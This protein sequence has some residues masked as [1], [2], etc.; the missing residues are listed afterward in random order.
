MSENPFMVVCDSDRQYCIRLSEYIR[1]NLSL[2]FGIEAYTDCEALKEFSREN[3]VSLL[4]ISGSMA[5][6]LRDDLGHISRN[7]LILTDGS[8]TTFDQKSVRSISKYVPARDIVDAILDVCEEKASDFKGFS[9]KGAENKTRVIGFYTPLSRSG[10]TTFA[11]HMG[12]KLSEKGRSLLLSF[13]SFSAI[14]EVFEGS[15]NGDITDLLYL[16]ECDEEE[17][18]IHLEKIRQK[19]NGLDMIPPPKMAMQIRELSAE[20]LNKLLRL[21]S[22][23]GGYE[24]ILLDLKDYPE[25]FFDILSMCDCI[26]TIGRNNSRDQYRV[27]LYN[28]T[29]LENGYDTVPAKTVK[30]L[31]PDVRQ[32]RHYASFVRDYL[33]RGMEVL[34]IGA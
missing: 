13:E 3:E 29:L 15:K 25:D 27:A 11:V 7:T 19:R 26:Y 18:L 20:R 1:R 24:Y 9:V 21:L 14:T 22:E 12:E 17:F 5:K 28:K 2:S 31:L 34:G 6:E 33:S 32:V 23:K 30:C 8:K 10:Q 16:A 4:V